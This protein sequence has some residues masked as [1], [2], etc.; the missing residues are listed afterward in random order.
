M[1]TPLA[2]EFCEAFAEMHGVKYV[3]P[4]ANGTIAITLALQAA[5]IGFGDEVIVPAFTWDGT[6]TAALAMG[7]VPVFADI[8]PDTY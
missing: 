3:L 2:Q 5:G 4:V 1:P 7:A 6:A 8:D